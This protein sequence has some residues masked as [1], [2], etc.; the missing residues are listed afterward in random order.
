MKYYL[1]G[2]FVLPRSKD[3]NLIFLDDGER[4]AFWDKVE[5]TEDW[6]SNTCGCYVFGLRSGGGTLP[7][8]VGKAERQSFR[9]ECLSVDKVKKFNSV[10]ASGIRGTPVLYLYA[11]TTP[12]TWQFSR[13]STTRHNDIRFVERSLI[14][15]ALDRNPD[16]VNKQETKMYRTLIVPGWLNTPPGA[17]STAASDLKTVMGY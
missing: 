4:A 15:F 16:L 1:Y 12:G 10:L 17:L 9:T 2:P 8:Y 5:A 7:W 6:L 13:P 11:R 14:A 3:D